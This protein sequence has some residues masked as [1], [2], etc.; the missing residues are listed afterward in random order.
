MAIP[1]DRRAILY[2]KLCLA[3]WKDIY[4]RLYGGN[5]LITDGYFLKITQGEIPK[6]A[7]VAPSAKI[8]DAMRAMVY[9]VNWERPL[10]CLIFETKYDT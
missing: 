6:L 1:M 5:I 7:D 10:K 4:Q 2:G 3:L 8:L 9:C